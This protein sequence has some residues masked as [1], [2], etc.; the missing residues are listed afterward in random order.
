MESCRGCYVLEEA[1]QGR[2]SLKLGRT[3]RCLIRKF[4]TN[5]QVALQEYFVHRF[6]KAS[7]HLQPLSMNTLCV[8]HERFLDLIDIA[9]RFDYAMMLVEFEIEKT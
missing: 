4:C 8:L 9:T 1:S 2:L 6:T 5:S 3:R 7:E